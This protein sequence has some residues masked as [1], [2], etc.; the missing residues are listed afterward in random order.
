VTKTAAHGV[1]TRSIRI[2][3]GRA[4]KRYEDFEKLEL[5]AVR[6]Y[7]VRIEAICHDPITFAERTL[8]DV[9]A[10]SIPVNAPPL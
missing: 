6:A 3:S 1:A 8:A 10:G 4:Q 2:T 7:Q 9:D 5:S